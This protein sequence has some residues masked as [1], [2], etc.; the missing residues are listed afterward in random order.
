MK[1]QTLFLLCLLIF[2]AS[3]GW[4]PKVDAVP[5]TAP[6]NSM[7]L[8]VEK[9]AVVWKS[10]PK[11]FRAVHRDDKKTVAKAY[12]EALKKNGWAL[13]KF[14]ESGDRWMLDM[15]RSGENIRVEFYDFDNTGVLIEPR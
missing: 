8:P 14:D 6:W 4:K 11:E 10:D 3:C 2:A 5:M 15:T 9:D 7:A 1:K 13:E 12:T